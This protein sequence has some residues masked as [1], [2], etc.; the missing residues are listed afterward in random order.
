[1]K[2]VP[3][4]YK[5]VHDLPY[6][7]FSGKQGKEDKLRLG[8]FW[9]LQLIRPSR[10][11]VLRRCKLMIRQCNFSGTGCS[12]SEPLILASINPK[13]HI[14]ISQ[15][16][17]IYILFF[18]TFLFRKSKQSPSQLEDATSKTK[19]VE[20]L[21]HQDVIFFLLIYEIKSTSYIFQAVSFKPRPFNIQS[22]S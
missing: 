12:F 13:Y 3:S 11:D 17:S 22:G 4:I 19:N 9:R 8:D 2:A 7:H 21:S 6:L 15:K 20:F 5:E 10:K 16:F 14:V 18:Y 1:M